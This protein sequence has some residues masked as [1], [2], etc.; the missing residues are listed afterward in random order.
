MVN[1]AE[2]TDILELPQVKDRMTFLYLEH[3]DISRQD[4]AI[5]VVD[6]E[7]VV[8]VPGAM[9]SVIMLGPGT[10]ITH[11]AMELIGDIGVSTIWVGEKG[12]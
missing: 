10:S 6:Q 3:C 11:R 9:I 7:G 12:V 4:G 8:L 1:G 5:K 2:K